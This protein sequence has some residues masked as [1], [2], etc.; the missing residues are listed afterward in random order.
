MIGRD[1]L[2][3]FVMKKVVDSINK[4]YK[5]MYTAYNVVMKTM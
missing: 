1:M 3:S 4:L 2:F 5:S